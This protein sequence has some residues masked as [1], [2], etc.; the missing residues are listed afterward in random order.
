MAIY[1]VGVFGPLMTTTMMAQKNRLTLVTSLEE[2][3]EQNDILLFAIIFGFSIVVPIIKLV[4]LLAVWHVPLRP[5]SDGQW[6][7]PLAGATRFIANIGKWAMLDVYV[8]A[9]LVVALKL[10]DFVKVETHWGLFVFAGSI[11]A[12]MI[13]SFWTVKVI[14][15]LDGMS[16]SSDHA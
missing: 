2:L 4:M 14:A 9:V 5:N 15:K 10:G 13:L 16:P 7:S 12:S 6:V 1:T 8:V 11:M 3:L